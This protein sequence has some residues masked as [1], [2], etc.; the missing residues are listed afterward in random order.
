[1]SQTISVLFARKSIHCSYFCGHFKSYNCDRK[2]SIL[3]SKNLYL[4][5]LGLGHFAKNCRTLIHESL[6]KMSEIKEAISNSTFKLS[7]SIITLHWLCGSSMSWRQTKNESEYQ[8]PS[9]TSND[10]ILATWNI[11]IHLNLPHYFCQTYSL[12]T[13]WFNSPLSLATRYHIIKGCKVVHNVYHQC[14]ICRRHSAKPMPAPSHGSATYWTSI[15]PGSVFDQTG[16]DDA[17]PIL[18]Y[19]AWTHTEANCRKIV[20]LLVYISLMVMIVHLE[21]HGVWPHVKSIYCML[22]LEDLAI[23]MRERPSLFWSDN[24]T[25]F[26]GAAIEIKQLTQL[27]FTSIVYVRIYLRLPV[28]TND[29]VEI[30]SPAEGAPHFGG[31][32]M[33][34]QRWKV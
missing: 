13:C 29:W 11:A 18:S 6:S 32:A 33:G 5:C 27:V 22:A 20:L 1:M 12:A 8:L 10:I 4:N 16:V 31:L 34:K 14:I 28:F 24:C 21:V 7:Q 25:N 26:V 17:G 2:L 3:K 9:S 23:A 15:T 19:K 30:H